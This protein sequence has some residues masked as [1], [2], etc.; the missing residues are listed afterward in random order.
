[1]TDDIMSCLKRMKEQTIA[2]DKGPLSKVCQIG[3]VVENLEKTI[4]Y[5]EDKLGFGPFTRIPQEVGGIGVFDIGDLQIELIENSVMGWKPGS[6]HLGFFV[7]DMDKEVAN[8]KDKGVGTLKQDSVGG[9]VDFAYL[10]TQKE[11]DIIFE[12]IKVTAG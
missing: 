6:I 7:E 2:S 5:L 11:S 4:T 10:D 1:M 9:L 8:L 12:L 3:I